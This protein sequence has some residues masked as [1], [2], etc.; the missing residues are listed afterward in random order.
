MGSSVSSFADS[1]GDT[2]KD[3]Y[4]KNKKGINTG[5]AYF[6]SP[7][8]AQD[9]DVSRRL[10]GG[11]NGAAGDA[12]ANPRGYADD[13]KNRRDLITA[14]AALA[15]GAAGGAAGLGSVSGLTSAGLGATVGMGAGEYAAARL[16]PDAITLPDI[17]SPA[18][19]AATSAADLSALARQRQRRNR[20]STILTSGSLGGTP[21]GKTLLGQ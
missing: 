18:V 21:G 6:A 4:N 5:A 15:G 12:L 16:A 17:G 8:I 9:I 3:G 1:V 2:V 20:A 14:N 11:G 7:L 19:E 10:G 13:P